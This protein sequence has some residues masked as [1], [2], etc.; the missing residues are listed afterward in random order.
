MVVYISRIYKS[1]RIWSSMKW[2]QS[3]NGCP[4]VSYRVSIHSWRHL[5]QHTS[6]VLCTDHRSEVYTHTLT[7]VTPVSEHS[8]S[9]S[10]FALICGATKGCALRRIGSDHLHVSRLVGEP[11]RASMGR[12]RHQEFGG[13]DRHK[14]DG[15]RRGAIHYYIPEQAV[16]E[17]INLISRSQARGRLRRQACDRGHI[18]HA[19]RSS[20]SPLI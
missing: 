2:T 18:A 17:S 3:T 19:L 11:G 13:S 1:D 9:S 10:S 5:R 16:R 20:L 12:H 15:V 14:Y 6:A 4:V 7:H 8:V